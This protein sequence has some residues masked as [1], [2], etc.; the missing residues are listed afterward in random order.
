[1]NK[2]TLYLPKIN[3]VIHKQI[4]A[5]NAYVAH[6]IDWTILS[7][8]F[9]I[10]AQN[11]AY[12]PIGSKASQDSKVSILFPPRNLVPDLKSLTALHTSAEKLWFGVNSG[13]PVWYP[14]SMKRLLVTFSCDGGRAD[15]I[16]PISGFK[17]MESSSS[18]RRFRSTQS[19][20]VRIT[21]KICPAL[22]IRRA[23]FA[24]SCGEFE[25]CSTHHVI[26]LLPHLFNKLMLFQSCGILD[27]ECP[28]YNAHVYE[29]KAVIHCPL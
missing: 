8:Y 20:G 28:G 7:S 12:R 14:F 13:K 11:D 26:P 9:C 23:C 25:L 18:S 2:H 22:V 6:S 21:T 16:D 10:P 5:F 29:R 24:P 4:H 27:L 3:L 17:Y 1:M 19:L 15:S